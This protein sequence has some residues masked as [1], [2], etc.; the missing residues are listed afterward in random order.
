MPSV[1]ESLIKYTNTYRKVTTTSWI[2]RQE[3]TSLVHKLREERSKCSRQ[4]EGMVEMLK[5]LKSLGEIMKIPTS[6]AAFPNLP[7][8]QVPSPNGPLPRSGLGS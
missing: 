4:E 2:L 7:G 3:I 1:R 8:C 5:M 6:K